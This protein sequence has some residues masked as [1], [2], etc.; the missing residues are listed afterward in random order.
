MSNSFSGRI[1]FASGKHGDYDLWI[2]DLDSHGLTQ[3]TRGRAWNDKPRWAPDGASLVFTSNRNGTP[4]IYRVYL[5]DNTIVPLVENDRWNDWPAISPDGRQLGFVSNLSGNNDLYVASLDGSNARAVT[6][7]T[8]DDTSFAWT[9]DGRG[10]LFSSDRGGDADIWR[11][12]LVSG[13]KLQLTIDPGH[14]S[15]PAPS[16]CGRYIAFV[17]DR[18]DRVRD[19]VTPWQ[20]RDQ[21]IWLMLADGRFPVRITANQGSDRCVAW[22]P[23]GTHLIYTASRITNA[24]ERLRIVNVSSVLAAFESCDHK[25]IERAADSLRSSSLK[26]NRAA[27][28]QEIE[29]QRHPFFLTGLLPDRLMRPFYGEDY[30]G[31]ERYP[32]WI[33]ASGANQTVSSSAA[34]Q[35]SI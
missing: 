17:S 32:S 22:S 9:P 7:H 14:D 26:I 33:G 29:A 35:R 30:F 21:D 10:I 23:D 25:A 3:V 8:G 15:H 19:D 12:D 18:Q 5:R 24:A 16:P 27:L 2:L 11:L 31:S 6:Q 28:E 13:E 4:G 1:A 20:D 34:E